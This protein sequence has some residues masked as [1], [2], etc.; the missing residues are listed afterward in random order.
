MEQRSQLSIWNQQASGSLLHLSQDTPRS[1][2]DTNPAG[3]SHEESRLIQVSRNLCWSTPAMGHPNEES[4]W[5]GQTVTA[6]VLKIYKTCNRHISQCHEVFFFVFFFV[7]E[8]HFIVHQG[9]LGQHNCNTA[10]VGLFS[11]GV[12]MLGTLFEFWPRQKNCQNVTWISL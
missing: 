11:R 3:N 1:L 10:V 4:Y 2:P 8:I 5:Q 9:C 6:P 12:K 7:F